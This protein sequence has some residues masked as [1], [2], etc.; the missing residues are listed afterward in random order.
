MIVILKLFLLEHSLSYNPGIDD[1][2]NSNCG[3]F[4]HNGVP[5]ER[6]D[7]KSNYFLIGVESTFDHLVRRFRLFWASSTKY[8]LEGCT[9]LTQSEYSETLQVPNSGLQP[10]WG[11]K[12]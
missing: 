9:W 4:S 10:T 5:I 8:R 1:Q 3:T 12:Y 7:D 11:K 6:P 2:G